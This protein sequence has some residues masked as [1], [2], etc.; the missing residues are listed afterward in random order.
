ML[1]K[2]I[3][4]T[5]YIRFPIKFI[6]YFKKKKSDIFYVFFVA[7]FDIKIFVYLGFSSIRKHILFNLK[8][9]FVLF[10]YLFGTHLAPRAGILWTRHW[11]MSR[12]LRT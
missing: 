2:C 5:F 6:Y 1:V 10:I 9:V 11:N 8:N 7:S 4:H 12:P 3:M